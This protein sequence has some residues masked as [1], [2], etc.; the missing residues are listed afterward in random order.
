MSH[1]TLIILI[2][3]L[4]LTAALRPLSSRKLQKKQRKASSID[5][6]FDILKDNVPNAPPPSEYV[7]VPPEVGPEIYVGS[8]IALVPI[9]WATIS[10]TDRI[11]IQQKCAICRGSGLV[12]FTK[13]GTELKRQRKCYNCGG[14]LPWLGWKAFWF[15]TF[16]DIGNGGTLQQPNPNYD[17]NN[18]EF[19]ARQDEKA[20]MRDKKGE[21][22]G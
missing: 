22:E 2:A 21:S 17:A 6:S 15:S 3:T 12:S 16:T 10:F 1:L 18:A 5:E 14:F 13:N 4:W 11:R 20:T 9:V 8:I 19:Q 7:F